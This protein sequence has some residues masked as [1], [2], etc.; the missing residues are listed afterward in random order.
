MK[1]ENKK[2]S[3]IWDSLK[4]YKVKVNRMFGRYSVE[5]FLECDLLITLM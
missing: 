5:R 2:I 3:T 4:A 1:N